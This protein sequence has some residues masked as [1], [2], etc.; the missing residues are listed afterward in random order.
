[1]TRYRVVL[2]VIGVVVGVLLKRS[3]LQ[4]IFIKKPFGIWVC[5]TYCN[6]WRDRLLEG[7]YV[8]PVDAFA[9]LL[10]LLLHHL[11]T[12]A[13]HR[14]YINP[15]VVSRGSF[16]A[17]FACLKPRFPA[18]KVF[19]DLRLDLRI[20]HLPILLRAW[21][22]A[23]L[24]MVGRRLDRINRIDRIIWGYTPRPPKSCK[25]CKSCPKKLEG[26]WGQSLV[27]DIAIPPYTSTSFR[28]LGLHR[29]GER[30]WFELALF[31]VGV[32]GKRAA[33]AFLPWQ[34]Y[35][36]WHGMCQDALPRKNAQC[37]GKRCAEFQKQ[38]FRFLF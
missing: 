24:G 1:M 25:S 38:L 10:C 9:G 23:S 22:S 19:Y 26:N 37:L 12:V 5:A 31:R 14:I 16:A 6:M 4:L 30:A 33:G 11:T 27:R 34:C 29:S 7:L 36:Y 13:Y 3:Q 20:E 18:A 28:M 8:N 21:I 2:Q 35:R 32:F 17:V 15:A